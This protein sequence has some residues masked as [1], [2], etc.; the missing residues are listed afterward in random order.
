M[1]D[2]D[3]TD[4]VQMNRFYLNILLIQNRKLTALICL[5]T[6]DGPST[7][8]QVSIMSRQLKLILLRH[9]TMT[10]HLLLGL[11][12][13][14]TYK[15]LTFCRILT[16]SWKLRSGQLR[17]LELNS[18]NQSPRKKLNLLLASDRLTSMTLA[19]LKQK[20]N[21]SCLT[22]YSKSIDSS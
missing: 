12:S 16:P 5:P 4:L 17:L 3:K 10:L 11:L 14:I 1:T 21:E 19:L 13:T 9:V 18:D 6:R 22:K 8:I 7:L 15:N 2:S 20:Y